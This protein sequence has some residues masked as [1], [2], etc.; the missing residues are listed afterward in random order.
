MIHETSYYFH[1]VQVS[2]REDKLL[3]AHLDT[4]VEQNAEVAGDDDS[5]DE[6][7]TGMG[8]I[9]LTNSGVNAD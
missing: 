5:E 4:L 2:E 3:N 8:D 9:D 7:D 1:F 6:E